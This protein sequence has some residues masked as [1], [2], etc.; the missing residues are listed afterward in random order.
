M[1]GP[2]K[3]LLLF[4]ICII[5]YRLLLD[6]IYLNEITPYFEYWMLYNNGTTHSYIASWIVLSVFTFLVYPGFVKNTTDRTY[7]RDF[8]VYFIYLIKLVPFS[9][10]IYFNPQPFL[11]IIS[12]IVMWGCLFVFLLVDGHPIK[13]PFIK[14]SN[15]IINIVAIIS[16]LSVIYV[17]GKYA[18]FR[19][20]FSLSDLYDLRFEAREFDMP[21][22]LKY[23]YS[24]ASNI[25]PICI[26]YYLV[27]KKYF[28]VLPLFF[29]GFLNFSIAGSK[30]ALFKIVMCIAFI[31]LKKIDVKRLLLPLFLGLCAVSVIEY[32]W[33]DTII[34]STL[35]VRRS[36]YIP[37]LLDTVYYDFMLNKSPFWYDTSN[38]TQL[39]FD[40]GQD[41]FNDDSM[42]ANNG[43][44]TDAY[45]NFGYLGCIIYPIILGY[46]FRMLD[47][48]TSGLNK[49]LIFYS[50]IIFI[51]T[52][53][54]TFITT[55]LLTHG[56]FLMIILLYL[57]PREKLNSNIYP[58]PRYNKN[59]TIAHL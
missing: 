32:L 1:L 38:F 21:T 11:F 8:F 52:I 3:K 48:A 6:Y 4:L 54:G 13:L 55:S 27:R 26:V 22:V 24:A 41:Y 42:R 47:G 2:M 14:P 29:I 50:V 33:F 34:T 7:T 31:Y 39:Q 40:I 18:N 56:L 12:E 28:I 43:F 45:V 23:L 10:L 37:N 46:V 9:S 16:C 15:G 30:S 19:L 36:L 35:L 59:E 25:I 58:F 51:A 49:G 53:E 57:M 17:S 44:F 20:H 5:I